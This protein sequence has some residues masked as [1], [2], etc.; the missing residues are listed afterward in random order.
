MA[1]RQAGEREMEKLKDGGEENCI[2]VL[3][4]LL[5]FYIGFVKT[6]SISGCFSLALARII[7]FLGG[8]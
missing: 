6:N 1:G 5:L 8:N 2:V 3:M 4:P 7:P